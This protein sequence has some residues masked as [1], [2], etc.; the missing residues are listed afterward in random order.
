[1][2]SRARTDNGSAPHVD[3]VIPDIQLANEKFTVHFQMSDTTEKLSQILIRLDEQKSPIP[4][5]KVFNSLESAL[6]Q[7]YGKALDKIDE[8]RT[9]DDF[10][11]MRLTR[12]WKFKTTTIDLTCSWD[13]QIDASLLTIGYFPTKLKQRTSPNKAVQL[14]TR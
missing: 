12:V 6:E 4:R 10:V 2:W 14:A 5:E 11:F 13:S 3:Y 8:R 7:L 9:S 1:M